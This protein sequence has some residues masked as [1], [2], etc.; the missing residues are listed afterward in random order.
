MALGHHPPRASE[1]SEEWSEGESRES[2]SGTLA[3]CVRV[4]AL[5]EVHLEADIS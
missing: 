5:S 2:A 4:A 1:L 3:T